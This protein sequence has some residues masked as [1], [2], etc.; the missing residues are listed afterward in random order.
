MG[1]YCNS[2]EDDFA[3]VDMQVTLQE[4]GQRAL[5]TFLTSQGLGKYAQAMIDAT[6]AESVEDLK[7]LDSRMAEDV[8]KSL[9]LKLISAQKFRLMLASLQKPARDD[10]KSATEV[11]K[12]VA[13]NLDGME[14]LAKKTHLVDE[15]I[16]ICID[17]S[18]SMGS[19]FEEV[20]LNVVEKARAQRTR[21]EAVKAMFY[22]FRDRVDMLDQTCHEI[23]L[24][25]FDNQV[26][27]MLDLTS[28]LDLFERIVDDMEKRGQTAI[29]SAIAEAADMLGKAFTEDS[30]TD[31]RILVLTD[32]QSN[33]GAQPEDALAAA[34]RIGAVVDAIIVGNRPDA[35]L[36]KIVS[37]TGGEC[38]QIN[39]LGDG[40]ELLESESVVSLKARRGGCD[41]PPFVRREAVELETVIEKKVTSSGAVQRPPAPSQDLSSLSVSPI[42][43]VQF[44]HLK[45]SGS[46]SVLKRIVS[47]MRQAV[48]GSPEGI[49]IFPATENVK[50][51]RALVEGPAGSPF[52]G[53]TFFLTITLPD[54]Y[55]FTAPAITFQTP[56]Y[57][58]NVSDVGK[59][60]LDILHDRWSP[61]L[62]VLK[63]LE[64]VRRLLLE[65]STDDSLRQWIA[66]LTLAHL[67]SNGTDTRYYDMA[68]EHTLQEAS[69][70][71]DE[72]KK[73]WGC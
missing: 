19:P 66:E 10:M 24:L 37:V 56:V 39:N 40:F 15:R 47:E 44:E 50:F 22:A 6:D 61:G 72:W 55:P 3:V 65:P 58:C 2:N 11:T 20:T 5:N 28:R 60:C 14:E 9:D 33:T 51:W 71:V 62:S 73:R 36:R 70:S 59:V 8:I 25:Q 46:S 42:S 32:G 41:K 48:N 7:L 57:H 64:A 26:D 35:N 69:C 4:P 31:L 13:K 52:E 63:C 18:G 1:S 38:Y 17:R 21:M 53:G 30:P 43:S 34:L 29:Y 49:H 54:S 27:R 23:G 67:K 16:V 12:D 45:Y 68:R